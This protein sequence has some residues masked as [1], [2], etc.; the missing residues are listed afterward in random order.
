LLRRAFIRMLHADLNAVRNAIDTLEAKGVKSVDCRGAGFSA[1]ET[2]IQ[3]R[4]FCENWRQP[5][6]KDY[7]NSS[8][9]RAFEQLLAVRADLEEALAQK[10][11]P[12]SQSPSDANAKS[13]AS[14]HADEDAIAMM[15]TPPADRN[16]PPKVAPRQQA[17]GEP[18]S[19]KT[20]AS[21]GSGAQKKAAEAPAEPTATIDPEKCMEAIWE[22]LIA[23]PPSR[24]RSMSTVVLEDTKVLLSS[25]EVAAFVSEGNQ[26]AEDL[27]RAVV[28]RSLLALEK[29]VRRRKRAC[30]GADSF[31]QRGFLF[32][33]ARGAGQARKEHRS[34]R[35]PWDQHKAAAV[36]YRRSRKTSAVT[37][38][39]N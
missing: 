23:M 33:G 14:A 4:Y 27:R 34:G 28:A 8:V 37:G 6:Q 1:A 25:W 19:S 9:Q 15:A 11:R 32:P 39:S 20:A 21:A 12:I 35:K 17:P 29:A 24:G 31:T 30:V 38:Q 13:P 2:T 36:I 22:Q 7:T 10:D 16:R 3:L 5:F 18:A 26:E